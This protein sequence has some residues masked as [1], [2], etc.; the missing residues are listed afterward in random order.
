MR[1]FMKTKTLLMIV[2]AFALTFS[3]CSFSFSTASIS[4]FNFGKN[5][6][7]TPPVATFDVGEKI[8]S[9]AVV[10]N[11][12]GKHKVRYNLIYENVPG[13]S[14]GE[15]AVTKEIDLEGSGSTN[16]FFSPPVPGEFK[17]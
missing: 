13:K 9:V 16:F 1:I 12:I 15:Q 3:A 2:L 6:T 14:K 10:S 4:S 7:A 17:V 8:N 5:N 11:A